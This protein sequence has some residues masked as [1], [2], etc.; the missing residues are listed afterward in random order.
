MTLGQFSR[1]PCDENTSL[2]PSLS[3]SSSL[4]HTH[5]HFY[6][7]TRTHT[8]S[9]SFA[10]KCSPTSSF[11]NARWNGAIS[12]VADTGRAEEST[13]SVVWPDRHAA[14]PRDTLLK[15]RATLKFSE[16]PRRLAFSHPH[17]F[18]SSRSLLS[19]PLY[20]PTDNGMKRVDCN[21]ANY[22]PVRIINAVLRDARSLPK[23][24]ICQLWMND[25][26]LNYDYNYLT[27]KIKNF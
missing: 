24:R 20:F 16:E 17:G 4:T 12:K 6:L 5:T 10:L 21:L 7:H 19:P 8:H 11:E 3:L 1:D 27:M 23:K 9:F 13:A 25:Y 2:S 22:F 26:S 15:Q 18:P 14:L